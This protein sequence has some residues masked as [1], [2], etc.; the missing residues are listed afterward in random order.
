MPAWHSRIGDAADVSTLP[1]VDLHAHLETR[2][3]P[4]DAERLHALIFAATRSLDEAERALRRSDPGIIWGVG[5]HPGVPAAQQAFTPE[6]FVDLAA[7]TAYVSEIGLDGTS[8]VPMNAQRQTF[9]S[10]LSV[11]QDTPRITSIHS[12]AAAAEVL[13]HLQARP[14]P[15]IVLH[16]WRGDPAQTRRAAELGCYFSVCPAMARHPEVFRDIPPGRILTET[17]HPFGDRAVGRARKPGD[18]TA[19]EKAISRAWDISPSGARQAMW[20]NLAGL[21]TAVRCAPLLPRAVRI[22]LASAR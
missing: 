8:P 11:L 9:D 10:I 13:E 7:E 3:P 5:C 20:R 12:F 2:I 15:G 1:P 19:A 17:D 18:V 16:W 14:A 21:V 6:R 22:A 4:E